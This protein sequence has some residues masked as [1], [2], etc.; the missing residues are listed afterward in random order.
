M[1]AGYMLIFS[2]LFLYFCVNITFFF[3]F[4]LSPL[5]IELI[6][7]ILWVFC[8]GCL[9]QSAYKNT[10]DWIKIGCEVVTV[11]QNHE[12]GALRVNRVCERT[13]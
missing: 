3:F 6:C 4:S 7:D 2:S 13:V 10:L 8:G 11:A 5:Y 9:E 12:H 1:G